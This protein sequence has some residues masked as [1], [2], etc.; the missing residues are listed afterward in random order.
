MTQLLDTA[1]VTRMLGLTVR[2]VN[3]LVRT[4]QI[5]HVLLPTGDVRFAPADLIDWVES[6]K[7]GV[8]SAGEVVS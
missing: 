4:G 1:D 8:A 7:R 6:R 3:A 2:Q 5:P